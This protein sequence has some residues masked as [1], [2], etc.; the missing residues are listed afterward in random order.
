[1]SAKREPK[2]GVS[3]TAARQ[4]PPRDLLIRFFFGAAI[5][6]VAGVFSLAFGIELGGIFL[7]FPAILPATLTLVEKEEKEKK[8]EDLDVGAMMGAAA[9]I[10]FAIVGW[11]LFPA[12]GAPPTLAAAGAAWLIAAVAMYLLFSKLSRRDSS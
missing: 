7:A 2:V 4:E 8:A 3:L 10:G 5:S 9:L 11:R 1:M 6:A 12:I